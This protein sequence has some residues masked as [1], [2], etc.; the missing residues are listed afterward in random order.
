MKIRKIKKKELNKLKRIQIKL[1]KIS[2]VFQ[3][4][5]KL[6]LDT[7]LVIELVWKSFKK[8]QFDSISVHNDAVSVNLEITIICL[9][10]STVFQW[11]PK[12]SANRSNK[13]RSK[14][15]HVNKQEEIRVAGAGM[16]RNKIKWIRTGRR[17]C[18]SD[19]IA[20][21]WERNRVTQKKATTKKIK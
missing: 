16:R 4:L 15:S 2:I 21:L 17:R 18:W 1:I 3:R 11:L 12:L 10:N 6:S 8:N 19:C 9:D 5:C 13:K 14:N 7:I 20:S